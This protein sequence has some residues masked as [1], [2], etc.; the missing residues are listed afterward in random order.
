MLREEE[1]DKREA[2]SAEEKTRRK[3]QVLLV[4]GQLGYNRPVLSRFGVWACAGGGAGRHKTSV[5]G[6]GGIWSTKYKGGQV[7]VIQKGGEGQATWGTN[8]IYSRRR[9][10]K[11][12]QEGS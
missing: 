10:K 9:K 6:V 1:K 7:L 8:I 2:G 11:Q 5:D 4:E 12:R 3:E